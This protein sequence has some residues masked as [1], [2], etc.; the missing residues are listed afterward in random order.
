MLEQNNVKL[1][2]SCMQDLCTQR[3][4][5]IPR[6][7]F[8]I[9][10]NYTAEKFRDRHW[11]A[12]KVMIYYI[13]P[14]W[15]NLCP[16]CC[17]MSQGSG[18]SSNYHFVFAGQ[19]FWWFDQPHPKVVQCWALEDCW[20]PLWS[21][22]GQVGAYSCQWSYHPRFSPSCSSWAGICGLRG[23]FVA[24]GPFCYVWWHAVPSLQVAPSWC[25]L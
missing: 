18:G 12:L 3:G 10:F 9:K 21:G 14:R 4:G 16:L 8:Q 5:L 11:D 1:I 13:S 22:F 19:V 25:S 23:L 24:Y 15:W 7:A 20:T 2:V 17:K 6:E